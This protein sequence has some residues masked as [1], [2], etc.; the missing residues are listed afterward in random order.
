MIMNMILKDFLMLGPEND[1]SWAKCADIMVK[2]TESEVSSTKLEFLSPG[3]SHLQWEM[4]FSSSGIR[5]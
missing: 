3:L 5:L 1:G 2:I 4:W